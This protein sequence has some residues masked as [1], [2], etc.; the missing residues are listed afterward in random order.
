[1][2]DE[3]VVSIKGVQ[4]ANGEMNES[5][6]LISCGVHK[7]EQ[8]TRIIQYEEVDEENQEITN[9]TLIMSPSHIEILKQG[10]SN[11]H[12]VF[13]EKQKT[14]SCYQTPFGEL[15]MGID[16]TKI[17]VSEEEDKI[18][19]VLEYGL[20]MNYNHIA[21]CTITIKVLAKEGKEQQ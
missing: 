2:T 20:D 17:N 5:V 11:V 9:V 13:E 16:T 6:E 21:D 12:M 7:M 4:I 10:Q 19:I 18:I 8:D 14:T 3:V 15:M 1:M